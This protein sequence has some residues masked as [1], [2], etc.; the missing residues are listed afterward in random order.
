MPRPLGQAAGSGLL[1]LFLCGDV[2]TGRGIDQVLEPS[3]D[4]VLFEPYVQSAEVYVG[5]A[6]ERSGDIPRPVPPAYPWGDAL[7]VLAEH[8]PAARI[9]NLET[10]VTSDGEPW[11]G[12][13]IHYR[14]HPDNTDVLTAA[15]LDCCVL[16]NNHVLD[17]G[18]AG[19]GETVGS[20]V[21][22]DLATAGAG[23]DLAAAQAPAVLPLAGDRRLLVFAVG[24]P[25]SGIPADWAASDDRAGLALTPDLSRAGALALGRRIEASARPGD[26][27][28]VSVHWGG[29]WGYDVPDQQREFA[30]V[31]I[32]EAGVDV[33]H[34]HSSHHPKAIEVHRGRPILYGCGDF[35]NDY[36]GIR[37]HEAFRPD[38]TL[39][40]LPSLRDDGSLASLAMVPL[41]IDRFR[42]HH[43]DAD[44]ARWLAGTLDRECARYGG[45]VALQD[46]GT[47]SLR[48]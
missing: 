28:I 11:P 43:A 14:M 12:K 17:W 21:A 31:L 48:W 35:L 7:D 29:N 27:V 26:L 25:S 20:L 13:G 6:E 32:E 39:M 9:V 34:G 1:T 33:V 30:H 42:L 45:S 19:L 15:D 44:D 16:A 24:H 37:G 38:L 41:R 47:L 36:E 5:L 10:A 18:R 23:K 3:V 40:Y 46:D 8:A 2:M 4:P 22:A